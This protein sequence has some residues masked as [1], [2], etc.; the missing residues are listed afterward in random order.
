MNEVIV[1]RIFQVTLLALQV[2][3]LVALFYEI[4]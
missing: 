4:A 3:T 2:V 1:Q